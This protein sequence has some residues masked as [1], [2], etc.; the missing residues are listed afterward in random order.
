ML[1]G[2]A[3]PSRDRR[4]IVHGD[5]R[6]DNCMVGDDGR[7]VAV[8]DWEI[9]TLGDPLADVGLL[10]GV[11]DRAERR[12][13]G[14][15]GLGHDGAGLPRPRRAARPLRRA[16]RVATSS[17]IDFYVAFAFWKL[18]CILEGVYARYLGGAL[19]G[20]RDAAEIDALQAQVERRGR[21]GPPSTTARLR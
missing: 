15:D 17:S 5:Y 10:H 8:L 2:R 16:S 3:S 20:R 9:C 21:R 19:G 14:V 11:L 6:L 13:V 12:A 7:V 18:A 1:A 4:A